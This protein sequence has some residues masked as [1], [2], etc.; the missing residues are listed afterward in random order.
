MLQIGEMAP[1]FALVSDENKTV[2]LSDL[3]G[4]RVILFF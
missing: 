2:T 4:Q 1:D 3:R